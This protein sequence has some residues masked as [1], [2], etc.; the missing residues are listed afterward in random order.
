MHTTVGKVYWR[1]KI[2]NVE[3]LQN[4]G[5]DNVLIQDAEFLLVVLLSGEIEVALKDS[6]FRA[7]GPAFLC[8]DETENPEFKQISKA[9]YFCIFFHP[10]FLN[11]NMTLDFIR[12]GGYGDIAQ[13]HDM[14]LLKPFLEKEYVVPI[15]SDYVV[16]IKSACEGL[17]S[18]LESQFDWYWSCRSRS[19][20][21]EIVIVL[22]RLAAK[23]Q[24][25]R[26]DKHLRTGTSGKLQDAINYIEGNYSQDIALKDITENCGLN[27][28][29]LTRLFKE[30]FGMTAVEYLLSHRLKVAKKHLAFT[31]I[32]VKEIVERC[33]FKT[34]Q[35]FSRVFKD[36]IGD[37]PAEFRKNALDKRKKEIG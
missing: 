37:S 36:K 7:K 4:S 34:V 18:E 21:M 5:L 10:V 26:R 31:E 1:G 6:K 13:A 28:T 3:C 32:P 14:F 30:E 29:S 27:H 20:F 33:G 11:I 23:N 24:E 15:T 9:E 12:A 2:A 22:E 35:H 19:Y 8:F 25:M 16:K 17:K